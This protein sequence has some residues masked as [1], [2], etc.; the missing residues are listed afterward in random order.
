M[1]RSDWIPQSVDISVPSSARAYDFVLGGAHNFAVDREVAAKLDEAMPG[2]TAAARLNRAFVGRAVRFLTDQGIRQFLDI[3]SG[4]PTVSNVHQVAQAVDPAC[5]VV[6]V[7][8]DPIAVAHSELMLAENDRAA[9][10]RADLRDVEGIL[11][12]PEVE[13]LLDFDRPIGLL[14]TLLLHWVPDEWDPA[15][16]LGRYRDALP[17]GS[18]F[19]AS[20]IS[21]DHAPLLRRAVEMF[22]RSGT[23]E[24]LT[25]RPHSRVLTFF[26]GFDL[27][28]PGLVGCAEWRPTGPADISDVPAVNMV[29]YGGVGRL[30]D[31][32]R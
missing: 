23:Q 3:G 14:M 18:Y 24:Q 16:L 32:V 26:D 1:V 7:D 21:A 19:A 15:G 6:Y 5:R 2:L 12:S 27:V 11:G 30:A 25:L 29:F 28:E 20:H 8:R 10:V 13:R 9:I 31:R 4:I 22:Q 17:A